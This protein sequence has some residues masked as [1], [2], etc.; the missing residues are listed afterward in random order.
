M[1]YHIRKALESDISAIAH[2]ITTIFEKEYLVLT[3]N[4]A[5]MTKALESGIDF[6]R[7]LIAEQNGE[8][9]GLIASSDCSGRSV[10]P[11][12]KAFKENL[13][14]IRGA[15]AFNLFS[16]ESMRPLPYPET[17]GYVEYVG[18]LEKARGKGLAKEMMRE[19]IQNNPQYSDFVLEVYDNNI[20]AQKSY[21]NFGFIEFNRTPIKFAKIRGFEYKIGMKY[22]K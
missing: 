21:A 9:I 18:V 20:P 11:T 13:G 22:S 1:E 14:S 19:I 16:G 12:K 3:K 15:I 6:K 7:F 10:F 4:M 17:T 5:H 8:I 2:T